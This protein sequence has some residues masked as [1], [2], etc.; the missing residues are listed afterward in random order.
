MTLCTGQLAEQDL[1][2]YLQGS[3]P[4]LEAR[5]F[6]EH[7][8]ECP[9]CLA[10]L[11]ALEAGRHALTAQPVAIPQPRTRRPILWP[12]LGAIAAALLI[13]YAGFHAMQTRVTHAPAVAANQAP[14]LPAPV[15]ATPSLASFADT[16]L[17]PYRPSQVRGSAGSG[18]F[19][20]A[21]EP[22]LRHHCDHAVAS[23]E[24]VVEHDQENALAAHFY[25]GACE[26]NLQHPAEAS[27]DLQKVVDAGD[28][29][30]QE[31]AMYY[32]AQ[33]SLTNNDKAAARHWLAKTIALH[34]DFEQRA[35]AQLNRIP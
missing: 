20:A 7:Y 22:Y 31:A 2:R 17:P 13:G 26:L 29:P 34:G 14:Q 28:S 25:R 32:L 10:Q 3:L 30:Q 27:A 21:M 11:E 35:K 33:A 15:I 16:S 18:L 19:A 24:N 6:E 23:L 9:E 4:E 12:T 5:R 1:E 8:F